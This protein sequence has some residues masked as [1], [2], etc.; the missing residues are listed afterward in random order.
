MDTT[1]DYFVRV[2]YRPEKHPGTPLQAYR[3]W[4]SNILR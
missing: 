4:L 2:I 1:F 3:I